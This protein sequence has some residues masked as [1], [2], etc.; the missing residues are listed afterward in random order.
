MSWDAPCA[1]AV[2]PVGRESAQLRVAK[3]HSQSPAAG[4][5]SQPVGPWAQAEPPIQLVGSLAVGAVLS[6]SAPTG[7]APE[8]VVPALAKRRMPHSLASI[9]KH[10]R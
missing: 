7:S 5:C 8:A 4:L 10:Q 2:A 6:M 3:H 9:P 1:A